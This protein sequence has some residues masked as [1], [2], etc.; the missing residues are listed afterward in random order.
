MY[1]VRSSSFTSSPRCLSTYF[2]STVMLEAVAIGGFER[3]RFEQALEHGVQAARAD[4]LGAL[5]HLEGD[6]GDAAHAARGELELHAFGFEQRAVLRAQRRIRLGQDANEVLD[7]ERIELDADRK[8]ALQLGNQVRRLRHVERAGGDEQDVIGLHH[9][10]LGADGAAF[11]QRQQVALHAFARHV[12]A[13]RFLAARDLVDLV[14]E[15]DAVL[16]RVA[17]RAQL[18]LFLVDHL[19][20]F[21][22]GEQLER[23]A[24]L[25][26]ARAWCACRRGWRT[27]SA[28]AASDLPC[29]RAP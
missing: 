12:G 24:H 23:L 18:Q 13:V 3:Q 22:V 19:R 14:D 28:A 26:L 9:A 15:H 5:V 8:A 16:L 11:D 6:F 27:C 1:R 20:R 7:L 4:V 21:F 10:V 17:Q 2:A 29:R 25:D